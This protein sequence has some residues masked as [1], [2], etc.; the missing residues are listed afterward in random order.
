MGLEVAASAG[1][2]W[3]MGV[4]TQ[5]ARI[6]RKGSNLLPP[7]LTFKQEATSDLCV[8]EPLKLKSEV[9]A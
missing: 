3:G 1:V 6:W 7:Y 8:L 4:A 2:V 5:R 9:A